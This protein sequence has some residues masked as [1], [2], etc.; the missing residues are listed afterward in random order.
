MLDKNSINDNSVLSIG[1]VV[2]V[3]VATSILCMYKTYLI[4]QRNRD[5]SNDILSKL[6]N[7]HT[8][9]ISINKEL[10]QGL[11]YAEIAV[12]KAQENTKLLAQISAGVSEDEEFLQQIRHKRRNSIDS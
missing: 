7:I 2:G 5:L 4:S 1:I 6:D 8:D 10:D 9:L 12:I 3:T 11:E